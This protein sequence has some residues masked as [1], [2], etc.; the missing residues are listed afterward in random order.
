M[1]AAIVLVQT[2]AGFGLIV[3]GG[4]VTW[5]GIRI[6][7]QY[8]PLTL[9]PGA[10][11]PEAFT[12]QGQPTSLVSA[13]LALVNAEIASLAQPRRS[14]AFVDVQPGGD[15][16]PSGDGTPGGA[17][18][19][20]NGETPPEEEGGE[21]NG[22]EPTQ[23]EAAGA[24]ETQNASAILEGAARVIEALPKLLN[25]N[26]GPATVVSIVGFLII[27]GGFYLLLQ[28]SAGV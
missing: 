1:E 24:A 8:Y 4:W 27:A 20:T 7:T 15:A 26:F 11:L 16:A 5:K 25:A 13:M 21:T 9:K 2:V 22:Q 28:L 14:S 10:P 17:G 3:F 6:I 12:A 18:D 19:A 23:P